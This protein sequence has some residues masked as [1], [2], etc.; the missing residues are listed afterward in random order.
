MKAAI[1][2]VPS[3]FE[4]ANHG[5]TLLGHCAYSAKLVRWFAICVQAPNKVDPTEWGTIG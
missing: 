2:V 1:L 3:H 4:T 5:G